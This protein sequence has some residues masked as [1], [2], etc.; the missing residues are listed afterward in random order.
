MKLGERRID[1]QRKHGSLR[2][3]GRGRRRLF[4]TKSFSPGQDP[5]QEGHPFRSLQTS[6]PNG[7]TAD[8]ESEGEGDEPR[9]EENRSTSKMRLYARFRQQG[10]DVAELGAAMASTLPGT[11]PEHRGVLMQV[12]N[13]CEVPSLCQM[14]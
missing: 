10:K 1:H 11:T 9:V 12:D 8:G 7:R 3:S 14:A 4:G 6:L 13:L 2:A 5:V